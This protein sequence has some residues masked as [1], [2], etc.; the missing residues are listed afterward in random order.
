MANETGT[1]E[2]PSSSGGAS[3]LGA[4]VVCVGR[5]TADE[6]VTIR[7]GFQ[8]SLKLGGR[9]LRIETGAKVEADI[10]AGSVFIA[11]SL[12]GGIR[13]SGMVALTRDAKM[14]GDIVAAKVTIQEGAQFRGAIKIMT[15]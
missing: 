2:F 15:G 8:G 13:A 7:G 11:G 3:L 14:K 9:R 10:E 4:S 12:A 1:A 5:V 6:D